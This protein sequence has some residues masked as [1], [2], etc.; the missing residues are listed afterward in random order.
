MSH[1]LPFSSRT[2]SRSALTVAGIGAAVL[3]A[4]CQVVDGERPVETPSVSAEDVTSVPTPSDLDVTPVIDVSPGGPQ[5][6]DHVWQGLAQAVS[7]GTD[8]YV[9][10]WVHTYQEVPEDGEAT[11]TPDTPDSV[12]ITVDD[13]SVITEGQ[14]DFYLLDATVEV[15]Q[16]GDSAFSLT[17]VD[18]ETR[19]DLLPQGPDD[20][21]RCSADDANERIQAASQVHA[22][23]LREEDMEQREQLRL[24]WG[25][26]PAVWW[27]IQRTGSALAGTDGESAGDFLLEACQPYLSDEG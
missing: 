15:E 6:E 20:E 5:E 25:A 12:S 18:A 14:P 22:D 2:R 17:V 23:V 16:L 4:G 26:S 27:G 3:V 10:A 13:A 7:S 8:A 24:Q 9:H 11:L 1:A 21:A 19:S